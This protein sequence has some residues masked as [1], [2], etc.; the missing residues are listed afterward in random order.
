ML[1]ALKNSLKPDLT[2]TPPAGRIVIL[3][4]FIYRNLFLDWDFPYLLGDESQ[5]PV[6][7]STQKVLKLSMVSLNTEIWIVHVVL[8][9]G[10]Y[11]VC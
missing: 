10:V 5:W 1:T 11:Q 3:G 6:H 4:L 7:R 2:Y 8:P 9:S